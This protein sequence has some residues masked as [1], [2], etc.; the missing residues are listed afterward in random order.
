MIQ[1]TLYDYAFYFFAAI[2]LISGFMVVSLKNIIHAAFSL[3]FTLLG[4]AG[5]YVLLGADFIAITQIMIYVGGIVVLMIF[6]LMLTNK[7]TSV[8]IKTGFFNVVPASIILG[9]FGGLLAY[10]L[11]RTNW[12]QA[13]IVTEF[14]DLK[15]IG[16]ALITDYAV[17]FELLGIILLVALIGAAT[18]ARKEEK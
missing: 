10:S 6:G 4:V 11:L 15:Q 1:I 14:P 7:I 18:I 17:I 13:A 12:R 5:I 3:L 8:E 9:F 16:T 2:I